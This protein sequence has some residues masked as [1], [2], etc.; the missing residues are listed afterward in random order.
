MPDVRELLHDGRNAVL[1]PP[2]DAI[3]GA[4]A[5]RRML[6]Q[7]EWAARLAEA[8]RAT[9]EGLTWDARAQKIEE[10]LMRRLVR[11]RSA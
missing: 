4:A 8:A 2:G 6:L 9:A 1:V 11:R 5:I 3:G 7:P 10:F